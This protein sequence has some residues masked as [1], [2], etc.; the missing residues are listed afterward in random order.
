MSVES[1][2]SIFDAVAVLAAAI[3]FL[4]GLGALCTG[5]ILN[6]RQAAQIRQFD[7]ELTDAKT[8]L[9]KQQRANFDLRQAI[10]LRRHLSDP[11]NVDALKELDTKDIRIYLEQTADSDSMA[12][13]GEIFSVLSAIPGWNVGAAG[14]QEWTIFRPGIEIWTPDPELPGLLPD[15]REYARRSRAIGE[16][17]AEWLRTQGIHFVEHRTPPR[18]ETL[19]RTR[20][21]NVLML[22]YGVVNN[23][24]YILVGD[25]NIDGEADIL[26]E[27]REKAK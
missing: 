25:R 20:P 11:G 1:W 21:P 8:D 16:A 9:V 23:G 2:K 24:V 15:G 3:T 5:N 6:K 4:A 18:P 17:I 19:P 14:T 12:L 7:S 27:K 22:E 10:N 26:R 13:N